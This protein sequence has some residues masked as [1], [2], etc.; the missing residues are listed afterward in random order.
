MGVRERPE[1]AWPAAKALLRSTATS[2]SVQPWAAWIVAAQASTRGTCVRVAALLQ[3]SNATAWAVAGSTTTVLVPPDAKEKHTR[4]NTR[5]PTIKKESTNK[6][7]DEFTNENDEWYFQELFN[8]LLEDELSNKRR[9]TYLAFL[10]TNFYAR[11]IIE[12]FIKVLIENEEN[13]VS[14]YEYDIIERLSF[15]E[16]QKNIPTRQEQIQQW[17]D[18]H[19]TD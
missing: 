18:E 17:E 9:E 14:C 13:F 11:P 16:Q 15:E 10:G 3:P 5:A 6:L 2:G 4:G 7:L 19:F 8:E 1:R 12:N